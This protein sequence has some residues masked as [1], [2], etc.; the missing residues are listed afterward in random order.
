MSAR[1]SLATELA[2]AAAAYQTADV[3]PHCTQCAKPCCKLDALVLEMEWKQIKTLWKIA[4]SRAVFDKRLAAGD[5]PQ[6]IRESEG[7]YFVHSKPCP[8]YDQAG[9][10]CQIY[11]Q[12]LKPVGCSDFPVY[13]DRGSIMADLR[14]EAVDLKALTAWIAR[15]LG[16]EVRIVQSADR[17]FPFLVTLSVRSS[18]NKRK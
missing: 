3:I 17:E 10:S 1:R 16:P 11:G 8:A 12:A 14:C 6:E 4:D 5:G 9:G 15:T 7:L 13:E 2:A 18:G